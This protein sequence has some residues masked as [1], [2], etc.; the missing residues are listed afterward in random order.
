M[1]LEETIL[2]NS[3]VKEAKLYG[4]SQKA[5]DN[6]SNGVTI[7]NPAAANVIH[8][9]AV[10]AHTYIPHYVFGMFANPFSALNKKIT[11][12]QI[13]DFVNRASTDMATGQLLQLMLNKGANQLNLNEITTAPPSSDNPYGDYGG[14]NVA[15]QQ[16]HD[17][18][19]ILSKLF[20][21]V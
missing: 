15:P 13:K 11:L 14:E 5:A 21:V 4:P 19:Y 8:D 9:C 6:P 16:Q 20:G 10:I 2:Q 12:D 18:V 7:N 1:T 17:N 3:P